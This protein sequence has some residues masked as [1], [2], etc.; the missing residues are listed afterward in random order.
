MTFGIWKLIRVVSL[1]LFVGHF[2]LQVRA[3][4]DSG[5][6]LVISDIHFDPFYDGALY[7]RLVA[8]P[9]EGWGE[10]LREGRPAGINP[11]GTDSNDALLQSSLDDALR[12]CPQPDFILFPGDFMA[13][14]WQA[15]YDKLATR[16][17]LEDPASYRAFTA[18][19]IRYV[20]EEFHR[21]YPET[22]ILT[23]LGN[24]D[25]YCGDYML[26]PQGPFLEMFAGIWEPLLGPDIDRGAFRET[27]SRGGGYSTFLPGVKGHRL[28]V[29]NSIY[30]SVNYNNACG[31][32]TQ[33]P[34]LD[35]L[36]WLAVTLEAARASGERVWLLM[37]V[38]PGINSFNSAE[39]VPRG[40]PP[41]TYW[42]PELT[43]RFL[44][45]IRRYR[46]TIRIAFAGHTH[47]DDFRM[48]R[49][50]GHPAVLCKIVPAISPIFGNNPG[51]QVYQYDRGTGEV[52]NYQTYYLTNLADNWTSATTIGH[53]ALEY[54]FREA[55]SFPGLNAQT[56]LRLSATIE[57]DATTR[58]RYMRFY[59]VSAA[60]EFTEA[61][62]PIYR[63]AIANMTPTEFLLCWSG[64]PKPTSPLP[65]PDRKRS[66]LPALHP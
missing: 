51:Y 4:P 29:L 14:Q 65:Y 26:E 45:L 59:G 36:G 31:L 6:F 54:E 52:Q 2:P 33:T 53:W 37:H 60:P 17:H 39:I 61:M 47:M 16:S 44:E 13:H 28:F 23:T 40:G 22:P 63:C 19:A 42:Q 55:Y 18:K 34:A 50:D 21:R 12:R 38:P 35:Q 62:F 57:T 27:F 48:I 25:S 64:I 58:Q 56:A 30:F 41:V 8:K 3:Q 43:S 7:Q 66:P 46:S 24:D 11:R 20:A 15:K 49:V 32:A 9:A 10:I 5:Q 1:I